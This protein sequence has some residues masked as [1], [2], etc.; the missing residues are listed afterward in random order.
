M[1]LKD[2]FNEDMPHCRVMTFGYNTK[3]ASKR[4]STFED[5]CERFL[6]EILA[7]RS[8]PQVSCEIY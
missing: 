8:S 6:E 7:V 2:F 5:F 4:S 1:W 3:L